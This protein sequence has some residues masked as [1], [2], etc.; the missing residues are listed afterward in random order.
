[1]D[2]RESHA[3]DKAKNVSD[4]ENL[5]CKSVV[6]VL[7]VNL[8]THSLKISTTTVVNAKCV[9]SITL[10]VQSLVSLLSMTDMT[11]V[12]VQAH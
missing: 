7:F 6:A 8:Y 3:Q 9:T 5:H 11:E 4:V 10:T 2:K 12:T 1:M